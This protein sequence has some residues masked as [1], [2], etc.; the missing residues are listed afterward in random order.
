M[1]KHGFCQNTTYLYVDKQR[2]IAHGCRAEAHAF[3]LADKGYYKIEAM[4]EF[5]IK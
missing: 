1:Y 4:E 2:L 5:I 3:E